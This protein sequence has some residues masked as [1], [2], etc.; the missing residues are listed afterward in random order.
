MKNSFD[1]FLYDFLPPIYR[2]EDL[3]IK[4]NPEPLK[5]F[6][7]IMHEGGF[8]PLIESAES[9]RNLSDID[10]ARPEDLNLIVQSLGLEFPFNMTDTE[11]RKYI[12]TIPSI[13]KLKGTEASFNFL[14]REIF[15]T[16]TNINTRVA[17]YVGGM[18]PQEWRRI[19]IDIEVDGALPDLQRKE[20]NFRKFVEIIR[21]VN[22]ILVINLMLMY[23]DDYKLSELA[24]DEHIIDILR[25]SGGIENYLKN[26]LESSVKEK[27]KR[28][29]GIDS[30]NFAGIIESIIATPLKEAT[31]ESVNFIN[32]SSDVISKDKMGIPI[33][34]DVK[35]QVT[36]QGA[37]QTK[38]ILP[39]PTSK[40]TTSN[41]LNTSFFTVHY[42][43]VNPILNY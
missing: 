23:Y 37:I 2:S 6:L 41:K 19:F 12:K 16:K 31:L 25:H 32:K 10:N 11:R 30:Y 35:E 33:L 22:R 28:L 42:E 40:L 17:E 29:E 4:P 3:K 43:P 7:K 34:S 14:A 36:L 26:I 8:K 15:S 21:P 24:R 13:Y 9:L 18:T 20:E 38:I 27:L 5:R 39:R 1:K